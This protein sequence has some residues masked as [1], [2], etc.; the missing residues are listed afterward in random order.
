MA[1]GGGG[2]RPVPTLADAPES[3]HVT[4]CF[5]SFAPRAG[6]DADRRAAQPDRPA[7]GRAA[8]RPRAIGDAE[9][10]AALYAI[11]GA[12]RDAL[13]PAAELAAALA[14]ERFYKP[15]K[16]GFWRT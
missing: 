14:A 7:A 15:E 3:L 16:R 13:G 6:N 10:K 8:L 11:S 5:L 4:L 2:A 9:G 12:Q 1:R